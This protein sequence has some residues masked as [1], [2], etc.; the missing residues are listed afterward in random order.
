MIREGSPR[1][2]VVI[3]TYNNSQT[4]GEAVESVL[5]QTY[6][7]TEIIV[8]DD[9]STDD[10]RLGLEKYAGKID[11]RY[12]PNQERSV[13]RNHGIRLARGRYIAF[14]DADDWWLPD[15]LGRQI[16]HAEAHPDLGLIYSW[17]N[18]VDETGT[19]LRVLGAE[20][21]S[22]EATGADLFEWFLLGNSAPT[23]SV[24]VRRECLDRVGLFDETITYIED[25]DLWMRIASKYPVGHV[26]EPLACYSVHHSYLP[27]VFARHQLQEKRLVVIEKA[28]AA[29]PEIGVDLRKHA[30][31][32]A[33]W[34]SA[35]IAFG[36]RDVSAAHGWIEQALRQM[37]VLS[38]RACELEADLVAFAFSLYDDFT[39]EAEAIA[40]VEFVLKN[41]PPE[42][43][44]LSRR[45]RLILGVLLGGY[46]FQARAQGDGARARALMRRALAMNPRSAFNIGALTTCLTGTWLDRTRRSFDAR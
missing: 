44:F 40:F 35:L 37:P 34:Y 41:L 5:A 33:C 38:G 32:R 19:Q 30:L 16:A 25:W 29:R 23:P 9:G 31:L 15:K 21:P 42:L 6:S 39:P 22:S 45:S 3:P 18:V 26:A 43:A 4:I 20:R 24:V 11:Y 12:Q 8:I 2:S 17:V 7:N 46:A 14:L 28:F 10:T 27:A 13:A 1:V 36:V